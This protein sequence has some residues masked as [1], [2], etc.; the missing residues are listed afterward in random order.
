MK[1][2]QIPNVVTKGAAVTPVTQEMARDLG[3]LCQELG[4]KTKYIFLFISQCP[5]LTDC[6]VIADW[7]QLVEE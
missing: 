4:T 3:T 5:T 1:C 7:P 6:S 2:E